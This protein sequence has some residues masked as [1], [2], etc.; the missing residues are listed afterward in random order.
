[1]PISNLHKIC[2]GPLKLFFHKNS[3]YKFDFRRYPKKRI[4]SIEICTALH[5]IGG[6]IDLFS[7]CFHS[8]QQRPRPPWVCDEY[9]YQRPSVPWKVASTY[10]SIFQV[11]PEK[12]IRR[13]RYH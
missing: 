9:V 2:F 8:P 4:Y 11:I 12:P 3:G 7:L 10:T 1:M 13:P 5:G 6:R